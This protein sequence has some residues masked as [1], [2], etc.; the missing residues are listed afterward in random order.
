L[1]PAQVYFNAKLKGL[2]HDTAL[3]RAKSE[4]DQ[5]RSEG[6]IDSHFEILYGADPCADD[7]PIRVQAPQ[8]YPFSQWAERWLGPIFQGLTQSAASDFAGQVEVTP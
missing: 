8:I 2:E 6:Q 7:W 4:L 5:L 1:N 3:L